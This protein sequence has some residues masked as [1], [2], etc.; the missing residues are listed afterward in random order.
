M[1]HLDDYLA[2][3]SLATKQTIPHFARLCK[4]EFIFQPFCRNCQKEIVHLAQEEERFY[5]TS[6]IYPA[7]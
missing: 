4:G 1:P 2:P 5:D 6:M 7:Q 3:I